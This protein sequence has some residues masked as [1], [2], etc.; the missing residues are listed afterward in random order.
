[1]SAASGL[2]WCACA[3]MLM[4]FCCERACCLRSFA[5]AANVA[6]IGDGWL[7]DIPP[8]M[9]LHLLLLPINLVRLVQ[10]LQGVPRWGERSTAPDA[11]TPPQRRPDPMPRAVPDNP[12]HGR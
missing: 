3:L 6:F 8:V 9:T 10:A 12:R 11:G 1:M 5:V 2:G 4:T 7:A